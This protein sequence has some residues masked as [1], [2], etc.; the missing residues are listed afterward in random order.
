MKDTLEILLFH[1][2]KT[3]I[4]NQL[5]P[6]FYTLLRLYLYIFVV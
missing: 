3:K 6:K 1:E 2:F 5:L 4:Y